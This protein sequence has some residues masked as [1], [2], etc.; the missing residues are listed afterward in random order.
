MSYF[1]MN[2]MSRFGAQELCVLE[3]RMLCK[4]LCEKPQSVFGEGNPGLSVSLSETLHPYLLIHY[5]TQDRGII[6]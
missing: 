4:Q 1:Q 2:H 3:R 6:S 5:Y